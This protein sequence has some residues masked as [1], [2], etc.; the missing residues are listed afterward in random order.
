MLLGQNIR[1]NK[2]QN[3]VTYTLAGYSR[4]ARYYDG[5]GCSI[6]PP[7]RDDIYASL[8]AK[9]SFNYDGADQD[10]WGDGDGLEGSML[11]SDEFLSE[12]S[13]LVDDVFDRGVT[14]EGMVIIHKGRLVGEGYRR[15]FHVDTH[16]QGWSS[17]KSLLGTVIGVMIERG[18]L[19]LDEPAPVPLW[20]QDPNDPRKKITIKD[21]LQM[22]GG[23]RFSGGGDPAYTWRM[24]GAPDHNIGYTSAMNV[25]H[26]AASAQVEAPPGVVGKYRNSNMWVLGL[27]AKQVAMRHGMHLRTY[28]QRHLFDPLGIRSAYLSTDPY[29][30]LVISGMNN[31]RARDWAKLAQLYIQD[32]V[33]RGRQ[34]ISPS[35]VEFTREP[36]PG[37]MAEENT[38]CGV[39]YGGTFW[40]PPRVTLDG[41]PLPR[42]GT[43]NSSLLDPN[44]K[45]SATII[46]G[47]ASHV[48]I[49]PGSDLVVVKFSSEQRV[50]AP[51]EEGYENKLDEEL[52]ELILPIVERLNQKS[53]DTD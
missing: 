28:I 5:H 16:F 31:M 1:F 19:S 45:K 14:T 44:D 41:E 39:T 26:F 50:D 15:P 11:H 29:G 18:E 52:Q 47:T 30:N 27:V 22:T 9:S 43:P 46:G 24:G 12:I 35:F 33:W 34:L 38:A 6:L 2:K 37:W 7:E 48:Y 10:D 53:V 13:Q 3:T 20:R 25:Y 40:V 32:G 23:L 51:S 42:C 36:A 8:P 49:L 21:L 17:G 4:T